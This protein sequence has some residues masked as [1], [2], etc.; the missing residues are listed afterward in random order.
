MTIFLDCPDCG[1]TYKF[2]DRKGGTRSRCKTCNRPLQIPCRPGQEPAGSKPPSILLI[3]CC[4]IGAAGLV[5]LAGLAAY[6]RSGDESKPEQKAKPQFAQGIAPPPGCGDPEAFLADPLGEPAVPVAEQAAEAPAPAQTN[7]APVVRWKNFPTTYMVGERVEAEA[8]ANDPDGDPSYFELRIG[9]DDRWRPD[10]KG[11]FVFAIPETERLVQLRA[12]DDFGNYSEIVELTLQPQ[13][14]S[15]RRPD[16]IF[17]YI[18]G[19][20]TKFHHLTLSGEAFAL[21]EG[22]TQNEPSFT[23]VI[24]SPDGGK[25]LASG[26][27]VRCWSLLQGGAVAIATQPEC[28]GVGQFTADGRFFCSGAENGQNLIWEVGTRGLAATPVGP[29]TRLQPSC[30]AVSSDGVQLACVSKDNNLQLYDVASATL[31]QEIGQLPADTQQLLWSPGD[32][33]IAAVATS[34]VSLY[35]L[36]TGRRLWRQSIGNPTGA[37]FDREHILVL[38]G[39]ANTVVRLQIDSGTTVSSFPLSDPSAAQAGVPVDRDPQKLAATAMSLAANGQVL[40]VGTESGSIMWLRASDGKQLASIQGHTGAV[41]GVALSPNGQLLASVGE[42]G[43]LRL[44]ASDEAAP[45]NLTDADTAKLQPLAE[46]TMKNWRAADRAPEPTVAA[47][48]SQDD[49]AAKPDAMSNE[50]KDRQ[51]ARRAASLQLQLAERYLYTD[52]PKALDYAAKA[53]KLAPPDSEEAEQA[54]KLIDEIR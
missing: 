44:W 15:W 3:L 31:V 53:L 16:Q 18:S 49:T 13:P 32:H 34:E 7:R 22:D 24:F 10:D 2:P 51:K 43:A 4:Y 19:R 39:G 27:L 50:E 9:K 21:H 37:Q 45:V 6:M 14:N 8:T 1:R 17:Q 20:P 54:R 48:E 38:D 25:L 41:L 46:P 30:V 12:V 36:S 28:C 33:R 5:G 42:D 47:G 26:P 29:K 35:E 52:P 23:G 40:G 11:R